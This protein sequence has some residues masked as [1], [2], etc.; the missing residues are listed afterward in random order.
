[1]AI[2][3]KPISQLGTAD[4][5]EL[6]EDGAVENARLEFKREV[7]DKDSTL[8]RPRPLLTPSVVLLLLA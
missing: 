3:A 4:L 2:F 6:L 5:Q 7:P 8:R 1:M